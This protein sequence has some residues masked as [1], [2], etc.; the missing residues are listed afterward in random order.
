[1]RARR[2][3][4]VTALTTASLLVGAMLLAG[5][6]G[7]S[8]DKAS[9]GG[10]AGKAS[11]GGSAGS[12]A[13]APEASVSG[14]SKDAAGGAADSSG[15]GGSGTSTSAS[16]VPITRAV[17]Y[18]G[19][20]TV[21]V[22][23]VAAAV[24]RAE[25]FATG[26]D[27][28]VFAEETSSE[29]GRKGSS[30][31]TMTLKV[32]PNEFRP[33]LGQLGRLGKQLSRS[34]TAS[35]VTSQAVDIE[36]RLRSQRASVAQLRALLDKAT[37]VGEVV[38]VEGQLSQREADLEALEAQQKR[39][40]ELVDLATINVSF[41]APDVKAAPPVKKDNLGFLSGLRGGLSAL[42]AVVLVTLTIAGALLPFVI[43]LALVGVPAFLVLRSRRRPAATLAPA[44]SDG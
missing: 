33:V 5:C 43:T 11:G 20:I 26:V 10:S 13:R 28:L 22:K 3:T 34:Q 40:G 37:T 19:D 18:H 4:T 7:G 14:T 23:D 38:Q 44:A 2:A 32:P 39:L 27:G 41:V 15:G 1:M 16:V 31:A 36:S 30:N 42:V 12:L 29:P 8:A 17:V 6:G 35:D 24:A 9:G 21:R 25:G